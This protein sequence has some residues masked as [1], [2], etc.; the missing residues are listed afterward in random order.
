MGGIYHQNLE[1]GDLIEMKDKAFIES[2][3]A[4]NT[5]H[6]KSTSCLMSKGRIKEP[7][8]FFLG[9]LRQTNTLNQVY[10]T[11]PVLTI[12]RGAYR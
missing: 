12:Q 4:I 8:I 9:C 7:R 6:F 10:S 2:E 1:K 5:N 11:P 3:E